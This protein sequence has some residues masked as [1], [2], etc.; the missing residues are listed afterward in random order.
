MTAVGE[1]DE[2][3]IVLHFFGGE[4]VEEGGEHTLIIY[5]SG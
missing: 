3:L 5:F 2:F 1:A 4:E